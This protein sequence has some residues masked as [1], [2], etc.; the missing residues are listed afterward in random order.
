MGQDPRLSLAVGGVITTTRLSDA[1]DAVLDAAAELLEDAPDRRYIAHGQ[2]AVD[3]EQLVV[4]CAGLRTVVLDQSSDLPAPRT[5]PRGRVATLVVTLS[6]PV[7]AGLEP[8]AE[9][10]DDDGGRL[11]VDGWTLFAG[12]VQWLHD[13]GFAT[14]LQSAANVTLAEAP[15]PSGGFAGWTVTLDVAL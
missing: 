7:C 8:S 1:L 14:P 4:H 9:Q 11:A 15:E 12:L 2:P 3:C 13:G 10:L 6:R 5:Q